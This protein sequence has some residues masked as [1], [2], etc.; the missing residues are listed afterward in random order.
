MMQQSICLLAGTTVSPMTSPH[1]LPGR[2]CVSSN[3]P[4]Q[5]KNAV[6]RPSVLV[7]RHIAC[8]FIPSPK[9]SAEKMAH[10]RRLRFD[11]EVSSLPELFV[12]Q[13]LT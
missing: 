8:L 3:Q 7:R 11:P 4:W 6:P 2:D 10:Q 5:E 9:S 1:K 12:F 13:A